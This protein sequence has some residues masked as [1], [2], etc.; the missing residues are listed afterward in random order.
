MKLFR[1]KAKSDIT[2]EERR[3]ENLHATE[4]LLKALSTGVDGQM[5]KWQ[6][7]IRGIKN[8][9]IESH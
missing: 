2:L 9:R 4:R 8:E 7:E 6:R 5:D 3:M 1:K